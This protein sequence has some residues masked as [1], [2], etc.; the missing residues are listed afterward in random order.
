MEVISINNITQA[1]EFV[2]Q[3]IDRSGVLINADKST[4]FN[5]D[6]KRTVIMLSDD[7]Q[8]YKVC[9]IDEMGQSAFQEM[10]LEEVAIKVLELKSYVNYGRCYSIGNG[11]T[12]VYL[13]KG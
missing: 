8:K 13:T 7:V 9:T 10:I 11:K 5:R 6:I 12:P 2:K 3:N 1:I 4:E